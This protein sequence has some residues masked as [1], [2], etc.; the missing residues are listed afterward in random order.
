MNPFDWHGPEFL[1]LYLIVLGL[2]VGAA[3]V[4]RLWMCEPGGEMPAAARDLSPYAIAYLSG[5]ARQ[6][7]DA[8]I[9]RLI[10]HEILRI[11]G[12]PVQLAQRSDVLPADAHTL[13]EV[14]FRACDD[15]SGTPLERVRQRAASTAEALRLPLAELGLV[16][17]A[18]QASL[19]QLVPAC[20]ILA[21]TLFGLIKIVV[22]LAR[23]RPVDYLVLL[24]FLSVVLAVVVFTLRPFRSW[25]GDASLQQLQLENAALGTAAGRRVT[26]LSGDDLT[27]ALGLFGM[28]VLAGGPL[29]RLPAAL[30]APPPVKTGASSSSSCSSGCGSSSCSGGSSGGGGGC[31]GGCGGGGC[32][33]CGS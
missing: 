24:V 21:G 7:T 5:G 14:V 16:L 3:L 8:A 20:V 25:R 33:G 27:L 29:A 15:A 32:G 12:S 10:H 31:G 26:E 4:V 18:S 6:A 13:E 22:G 2:A 9:I 11:T 30:V 1:T 23:D 28:G 19:A 17:S